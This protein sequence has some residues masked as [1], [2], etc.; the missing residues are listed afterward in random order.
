MRFALLSKPSISSSSVHLYT[1]YIC[2]LLARDHVKKGGQFNTVQKPDHVCRRVRTSYPIEDWPYVHTSGCYLYNICLCNLA[3]IR[4]IRFGLWCLTPLS[5]IFQL[6]R[7]SQF[8]WWG[9]NHRPVASHWQTLPHNV[10]SST[11]RHERG[12][13]SQ[14]EWR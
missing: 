12:S 10:V 11:P 1:V 7:G 5:T 13:N 2:T 8:Y 6:Y 4:W 14:L 3:H 9:K